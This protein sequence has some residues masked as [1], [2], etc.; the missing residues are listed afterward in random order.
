MTSF[1]KPEGPE[2]SNHPNQDRRACLPQRIERPKGRGG[3]AARRGGNPAGRRDGPHPV[4]HQLSQRRRDRQGGLRRQRAHHQRHDLGQR[5][6]LGVAG[7][8]LR[9]LAGTAHHRRGHRDLRGV[10]HQRHPIIAR[11]AQILANGTAGAPIVFSSDQPIGERG[12]ADWGGLIING[13]APLNVPGGEAVGEGD[14][15]TYGGSDPADDSGHLRYVRVEFAGTEFSP[16]NELNGIAFPGRG[17]QHRGRPRDGQV[18][19]GRRPRILRGHRRG[20]A[21]GA[22]GHRRRQ[23]RLDRRVDRQGAVHHRHAERRRRRPGHR[24]G[25]QRRQQQPHAAVE[26][27]PLQPD[28]H[29]RSRH[30]RGQRERHRDA[31]ARGHLRHHP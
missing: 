13:R 14:T 10:R 5:Q 28:P 21:R 15:G 8:G 19:Q 23:R 6:L 27:D 26:P 24:G 2:I 20:E 22:A 7:G 25:Q 16:D 1:R 30:R 29:R 12:R 4:D 9:R 3:A 18:Q 11:G 17:Q 31:A